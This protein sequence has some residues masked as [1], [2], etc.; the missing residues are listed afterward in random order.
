MVGITPLFSASAVLVPIG[1]LIVG[2]AFS[3]DGSP[4]PLV[5]GAFLFVGV[6]PLLFVW[7]R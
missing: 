3:T 2:L 1:L 7:F 4:R 6:P 5:V